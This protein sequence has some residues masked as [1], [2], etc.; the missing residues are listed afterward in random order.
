MTRDHSRRA[1]IKFASGAKLKQAIAFLIAL[2]ALIAASR[3]QTTL[4]YPGD[5]DGAEIM[6]VARDF[7]TR[8]ANADS[9]GARVLFVGS[10][11]QSELL[12][13]NLRLVAALARFE[14]A[15]R[16]RFPTDDRDGVPGLASLRKRVDHLSQY[17]VL[18]GQALASV[19]A[20]SPMDDGLRLKRTGAGW[21]VIALTTHM[22]AAV[23]S[24]IQ[25]Y[26]TMAKAFEE[27]AANTDAGRYHSVAE[28]SHDWDEKVNGALKLLTAVELASTTRPSHAP[29]TQPLIGVNELREFL[30][31]KFPSAEAR[32]LL[33]LLP[34][35]PRMWAGP[36]SI[37]ISSFEAGI[38]ARYELASSKLVSIKL[39]A[40]GEDGFDE[41][42]GR[43]LGGISFRD[44]RRDVEQKLGR[45]PEL[46]GA[47][48]CWVTYPTL[49]LIIS[50]H[51]KSRRDLDATIQVLTLIPPDPS[52][53]PP[54]TEPV[55]YVP[56]RLA[57]LLVVPPAVPD[58]PDIKLLP[59]PDATGPAAFI[60]V[61]QQQVLLDERAIKDAFVSLG[62][63]DR[64]PAIDFQ[65]TEAGAQ[66]LAKISSENRGGR[67]A[68][69]VDGE[70]LLTASIRTRLSSSII[71]TC[72][73]STM[74]RVRRKVMRIQ[75][76]IDA[77]PATEP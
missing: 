21:R 57:F 33:A 41:Y 45:A 42:T 37:E 63:N 15:V 66:Q 7:L 51:G 18:V 39:H 65:M 24:K 68:I 17:P 1:A 43:L 29:S 13:A 62:F 3:A 35:V 59:D 52:G 8:V 72:P 11:Q 56:G 32:R 14:D 34:E 6:A 16:K 70:V 47:E 58:A 71:I 36:N 74:E 76:V 49:G 26:T 28:L 55:K 10:A 77:V 73:D 54:T 5:A 44:R 19:C 9:A 2:L 64:D 12:D 31:S 60:R 67:L 40:D 53:D 23:T 25:F 30:G 48:E 61:R 75:A 27:T 4:V 20:T 69:V 22:G 50:Y 46:E 38:S